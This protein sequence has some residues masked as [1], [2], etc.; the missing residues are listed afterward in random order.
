[1][2]QPVELQDFL[3][4]FFV[5]A[6]IILSGAC[7]ALLY[8]WARL[9]QQRRFLYGAW[10]AYFVLTGCVFTLIR[11]AHLEGAWSSLALLMLVGYFAAPRAIFRLCH[12]T[13]T[14]GHEPSVSNPFKEKTP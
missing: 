1:M 11:T 8:A 3:L 2:I 10:L 4:T 14:D 5:S 13:H 7:Y 6:G 9:R 12:V